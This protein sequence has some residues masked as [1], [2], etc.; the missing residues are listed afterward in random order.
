MKCI[1]CYVF[2]E[3]ED[4]NWDFGRCTKCRE[5][6]INSFKADL[7]ESEDSFDKKEK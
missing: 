7:K 6:F 4:P 3:P 2:Y 1:K 5:A